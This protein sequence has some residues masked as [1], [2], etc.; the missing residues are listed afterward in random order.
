MKTT[1]YPSRGLSYSHRAFDTNSSNHGAASH[2][3][4]SSAYPY[5]IEVG[6]HQTDKLLMRQ[7]TYERDP[8]NY[9]AAFEYF[10]E[11][12]RQGKYLT[13]IRLYQRAELKFSEKNVG[14]Y[15]EKIREQYWYAYENMLY[16][17]KAL[18]ESGSWQG[19]PGGDQEKW[20][21]ILAPYLKK[22]IWWGFAFG[23]SGALFYFILGQNGLGD[24]NN[25]FE[26]KKAEHIEQR[27]DDV[28]G[29]DEIRDE[30]LNI[31]K[32]I[33][34]PDLYSDK[35]AKLFKGVMLTGEPGTGKTLLARAIAGEA[36]CNFI[37]CSGS[38]FDEMFVG[39]GARRVKQL[40]AEA[41]KNQPCIIFI[42]E[43]DSLLSG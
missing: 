38:D 5:A 1:S 27:L 8:L 3:P 7:K 14:Q 39:V 4:D 34:S 10:R 30:I 21:D 11:L 18:N 12:N 9:E 6:A 24:M 40:F 20:F 35:G 28:K 32:I 31:I 25:K 37:F 2:H 42:D 17:E 43:I 22:Y 15:K 29:I 33:K 26:I 36:G 13:V 41:R 19:G 16:L 23:L